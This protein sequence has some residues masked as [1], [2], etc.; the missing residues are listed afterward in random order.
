MER[1]TLTEDELKA[2]ESKSIS[3][4]IAA[5]VAFI[6]KQLKDEPSG[7]NFY[8]SNMIKLMVSK[9]ISTGNEAEDETKRKSKQAEL[10]NLAKNINVNSGLDEY[11]AG[12]N[13][14]LQLGSPTNALGNN[15]GTPD[16]SGDLTG[17]TDENGNING[18]SGNNG[19]SNDGSNDGNNDGN[20][21]GGNNDGGNNNGNNNGN[22]NGEEPKEEEK[23]S[24]W[25][26]F[27][28]FVFFFAI[29]GVS[30]F[31]WCYKFKT[32]S[33]EVNRTIGTIG[34]TYSKIKEQQKQT[35]EPLLNENQ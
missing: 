9:A 22:G 26:I 30:V 17:L 16:S 3:D 12:L 15:N 21:D 27:G 35:E 5:D 13:N 7:N 23:A 2:Y 33:N 25:A 28:F 34:E 14:L 6:E 19:G 29:I 32:V 4:V 11:K 8:N 20:N 10:E 31:I 1:Y 24:G 18:G